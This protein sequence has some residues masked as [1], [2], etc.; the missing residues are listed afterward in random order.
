MVAFHLY[1][2]THTYTPNSRSSGVHYVHISGG[3]TMWPSNPS[4]SGESIIIARTHISTTRTHTST[5][6]QQQQRLYKVHGERKDQRDTT[7]THTRT[8]PQQQQQ[9]GL[10]KVHG[11]RKDQR[12]TTRTHTGTTPPQQQQQGQYKVHGE[13][14]DQR[15]TREGEKYKVRIEGDTRLGKYKVVRERRDGTSYLTT[16]NRGRLDAG[17]HMGRRVSKRQ[18]NIMDERL[19]VPKL[20]EGIT[21]TNNH[22]LDQERNNNNNNNNREKGVGGALGDYTDQHLPTM[23]IQTVYNMME[24][25]T[26]HPPHH[27]HHHH[28]TITTTTTT[29]EEGKNIVGDDMDVSVYVLRS[30]LEELLAL[31]STITYRCRKLLRMGG[32]YCNHK[33]DGEKRVCHDSLLVPRDNYC[34]VYSLGVGHD[35]SFDLQED[36]FGCDVFTFDSDRDHDHYPTFFSDRLAFYKVRVGPDFLKE[37][38]YQADK[39][40]AGPHDVY[41]WPLPALM[42]RLGHTHSLLYYLKIDVEGTEWDILT[43]LLDHSDILWRTQQLGLEIHLDKLRNNTAGQQTTTTTTQH[44]LQVVNKYIRVV[45]GLEERG[46]HLT[47]WEPNYRLPKSVTLAGITFHLYS[48]TLWVNPDAWAINN[49]PSRQPRPLKLM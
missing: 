46:F 22:Q 36:M 40:W 42:H 32:Y 19:R 33:P 4:A 15:D 26:T 14:K 21:T 20:S 13:R 38:Q 1:H 30:A 7:R 18:Q 41:Y 16:L 17:H 10:Y 29:T 45:R 34:L 31:L 9:Q 5:T 37:T 3:Q 27:H 8:T 2:D 44:L 24:T 39:L 43:H 23:D 35:L 48:E 47:H 6:Q 28:H 11:E 25:N 12:D 49:K